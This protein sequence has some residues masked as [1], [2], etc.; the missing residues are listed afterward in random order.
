M[1]VTV[2]TDRLLIGP[3]SRQSAIFSRLLPL[4]SSGRGDAPCDSLCRYSTLHKFAQEWTEH[5]CFVH[6]RESSFLYARCSPT[7]TTEVQSALTGERG[8]ILLDNDYFPLIVAVET[9]I[10]GRIVSR[11]VSSPLQPSSATTSSHRSWRT[12]GFMSTRKLFIYS[13][14][15]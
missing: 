11:S 14:L 2:Q 7:C 1:P 8:E 12:R 6:K 10:C 4:T 15:D 3:V 13:Y 9:H 5:H